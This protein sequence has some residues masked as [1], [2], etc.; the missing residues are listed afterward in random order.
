MPIRT[1]L[2]LATFLTV[3]SLWGQ[4]EAERDDALEEMLQFLRTTPPASVPGEETGDYM[5][6]VT[7]FSLVYSLSSMPNLK[8]KKEAVKLR[9][10]RILE[11]RFRYPETF[12]RIAAYLEP[13]EENPM[14]R[15]LSKP[16]GD[17][18]YQITALKQFDLR[19]LH[20]R[21]QTAVTLYPSA[22]QE[23]LREV[24]N[25]NQQAEVEKA[26][27]IEAW[28]RLKTSFEETM[29]VIMN[30]DRIPRNIFKLLV[31]AS[32]YPVANSP[33]CNPEDLLAW[34]EALLRPIAW[35]MKL[36][37]LRI[38]LAIDDPDSLPVLGEVLRQTQNHQSVT[39]DPK[40]VDYLAYD[41][42]D[43]ISMWPGEIATL[44]LAHCLRNKDDKSSV[45]LRL[46]IG[47][48]L[49]LSQEWQD[50]F[51]LGHTQDELSKEFRLLEEAQQAYRLRM[52]SLKQE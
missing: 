15:L 21:Y 32:G 44:E 23:I 14:N 4:N 34:E 3:S 17:R 29:A 26:G 45:N 6:M 7:A 31:E 40:I 36:H 50:F 5:K 25:L 51:V 48:R 41:S 27:D 19:E 35:E 47:G 42:L 18:E 20:S 39:V 22:F 13:R 49:A 8:N 9:L 11:A 28:R 37:I 38:I 2:W 10:Y 24:E 43:R 16:R 46:A 1:I 33:I 30:R 52:K 12:E